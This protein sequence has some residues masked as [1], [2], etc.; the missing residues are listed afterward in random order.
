MRGLDDEPLRHVPGFALERVVG[1][2]SYSSGREHA[3][4]LAEKVFACV[5][6]FGCLDAQD[7]C[8]AV[9]GEREA[10]GRPMVKA[11]SGLSAR[12]LRPPPRVLDVRPGLVEGVYPSRVEALQGGL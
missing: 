8:E 9:A 7:L 2:N 1:E 5:E 10:G 12:R 11:D 4:S 6:V 3:V